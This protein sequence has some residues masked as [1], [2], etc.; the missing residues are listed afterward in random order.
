MRAFASG[1][2]QTRRQQAPAV[3][4]GCALLVLSACGGGIEQDIRQR[5]VEEY[6]RELCVK[7]GG[8]FPLQA[9]AG[10]SYDG[11]FQ[12]LD[13]LTE[14]GLLTATAGPPARGLGAVLLGP[15]YTF[16]LTDAGRK[17]WSA[18][19]GFC[20]GRTVVV[21]VIDYTKPTEAMGATVVQAE[22][23][24]RHEVTAPWAE[25]PIVTELAE[26]GEETVSMVLVKKEKGG[27]SP[28]Y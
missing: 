13:A 9:H 19:D 20:Y 11:T 17:A 23:R 10:G 3:A 24:L 18:E 28:A 1:K 4:A 25:S 16:D 8:V 15:S 12:W 14:A 5:F 7:F 27:W 21:E 22:A 2:A 6:E 26:R